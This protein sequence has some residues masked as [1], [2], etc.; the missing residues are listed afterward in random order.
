MT[1]GEQIKSVRRE[2]KMRQM[3][4]PGRVR[5]RKMTAA[6][7]AYEIAAMEAVLKTL[8]GIEQTEP[9]QLAE[10]N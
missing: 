2:I 10:E 8:Q 3:V 7:A 1:I 5:L 9:L 6:A 4:Y